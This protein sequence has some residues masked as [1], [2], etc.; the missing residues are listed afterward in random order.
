M[1]TGSR[2]PP[3]RPSRREPADG[4]DED[5]GRFLV[6]SGPYMIEGSEELDF[7][8]PPDEQEPADGFVPAVLTEDG[9][10]QEPGSLVLVSNPSWDP[11]YR[12]TSRR[13]RGSDRGHDRAVDREEIARRVD[14]AE[15]DF[16]FAAPSPVR[17]GR[18][19]PGRPCVGASRVRA[20]EQ[21][22]LLGDD[23]P[24]RPA[25]RRRPRPPCRGSSRSTRRHSSSCSRSRP[26]VRSANSWGEVATHMAPDAF[27][28][29]LLRAFDPTPT[30]PRRPGRRCEP[31]PTIGQATAVAM[32]EHAGTSEAL[33]MDEGVILR[34]GEGDPRGPG[35]VGDRAGSIRRKA[36]ESR[37]PRFCPTVSIHD[38][39][40]QIPMG[41]A[42]PWGQDY[43]DGGGWF[44]SV[45]QRCRR[46]EGWN[47]SLARGEP[48]PSYESGGTRSPRSRAWMIVSRLVCERRGV[49]RTQCWAELDQYLTTEV[50]SR[51]PYFFFAQRAGGL[52]AGRRVLVRP[53]HSPA[54]ARPD[55][56][57]PRL[58]VAAAMSRSIVKRAPLVGVVT[59]L[60]LAAACTGEDRSGSPPPA[61][62]QPRGGTLR[63]AIPTGY[64][65]GAELDPQR[66]YVLPRAHP[67]LPVPNPVLVQRQA[68]GRGGRRTPP[69]PCGWVSRGVQRRPPLD[70][71]PP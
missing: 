21:R 36:L 52:G 14:T 10:A 35:R 50:V 16:V 2:C 57:R 43:P 66:A 65:A 33:V 71:P 17:P 41:I 70:L 13:L 7:S 23:E 32:R 9:A 42:Y 58:R 19:V 22:L 34:A 68:D 39:G 37:G 49:T 63:L 20:P 64:L 25:V 40:A 54:G 30:T 1:R 47:T 51:V 48:R 45:R 8:V 15:L 69:G 26:T 6:A 4:H 27:E 53:V 61:D 24:R 56:P 55:R 46:L 38:P 60:L 59:I 31:P 29:R 62:E 5:Y 28:G 11:R 44:R 18:P 12:S 67:V 3:R